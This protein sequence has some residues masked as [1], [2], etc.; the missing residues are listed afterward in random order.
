MK[1]IL[2]IKDNK[3]AFVMELLSNLSFVKARPLS[4]DDVILIEEIKQAVEEL[5]L[6][7]EGKLKTRPA[8][9]LINEL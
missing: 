8:R 2:D 7:R 6:V 3:A 5:K 9:D 1:V 4:E